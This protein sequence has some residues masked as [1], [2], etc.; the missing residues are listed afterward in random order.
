MENQKN[1]HNLITIEA[2]DMDSSETRSKTFSSENPELLE[3]AI[4]EFMQELPFRKYELICNEDMDNYS[5]DIITV[6]NDLE[7]TYYIF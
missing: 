2:N 5:D 6:L 7:V 3:K 4:K 1:K